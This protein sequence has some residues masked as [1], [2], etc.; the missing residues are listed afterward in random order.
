M[1]IMMSSTTNTQG[2]GEIGDVNHTDLRTYLRRS[3][4]IRGMLYTARGLVS[5]LRTLCW[6]LLR[7]SKIKQYLKMNSVR[8]LQLGTS[9]NILSGW[10][11]TDLFPSHTTVV[12][13]DAT[14]RFPLDDNT[15]DY[16]ISEHMIE[17]VDYEAGEAMLRE[18]FR[19]LKP[20]GR[21]RI[22]TPD[23]DV[24]VGL[25]SKEKTDAQRQ[26]VDWAIAKFVPTIQSNKDV[27]VINNFFRAWGHRF[28]YD[29]DTLTRLLSGCGFYNIASCRPGSSNDPMLRN[30]ESHGKTVGSEVMN[31]FETI[32]LECCKP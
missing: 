14:K 29:E 30:L 17:H 6:V 5:D 27:F 13:L 3:E 31:R 15:F 9:D 11:N 28:I 32:V 8:K 19:V 4:L 18:C 12:F 26:Y 24:V 21:L 16:I 23:L 25:H 20:G 1:K 7:N 10:L 22:A 2:I